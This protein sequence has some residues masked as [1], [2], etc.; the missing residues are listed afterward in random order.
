MIVYTFEYKGEK[1]EL[2]GGGNFRTSEGPYDNTLEAAKLR[3]DKIIKLRAKTA[4]AALSLPV[5]AVGSTEVIETT[6]TGI[7]ARLGT[8]IAKPPMMEKYSTPHYYLRAPE[9]RELIDKTLRLFTEWKMAC[10]ELEAREI[11][12]D[13]QSQ[14]GELKEGEHEQLIAQILAYQGG[15]HAA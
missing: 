13:R 15:K 14:Y 8:I 12:L 3:V 9:N 10:K 6:I 2:D 11:V 5:Y 1:I 4:Q 7:H